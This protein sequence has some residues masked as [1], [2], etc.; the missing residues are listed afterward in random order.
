MISL[1]GVIVS[2]EM[3]D[4]NGTPCHTHSR[5]AWPFAGPLFVGFVELSREPQWFGG[6]T[7]CSTILGT[8]LYE[9]TFKLTT[10][11][12]KSLQG[13]APSVPSAFPR[14][15]RI[16]E[17]TACTQSHRGMRSPFWQFFLSC[18]LRPAFCGSG[19]SRHQSPFQ[20]PCETTRALALSWLIDNFSMLFR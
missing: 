4:H 17:K 18:L 19:G 5:T 14:T 20:R 9:F 15:R 13:V 3:M 12:I 1:A 10:F 8:G 7:V 16:S 6:P 11:P 2:K